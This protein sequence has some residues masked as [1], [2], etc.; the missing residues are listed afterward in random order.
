MAKANQQLP[1]AF[2]LFKPSWKAVQLNLITFIEFILV[3]ALIALIVSFLNQGHSTSANGLGDGLLI[4]DGLAGLVSLFFAPAIALTQLR[5]VKGVKIDFLPA[6]KESFAFFWKFI[7]LI[8]VM[9]LVIGIGFM[10]LI[11]PGLFMLR[12]YILAPYY[13]IDK[14]TGVFE[15]MKISAEQSK[16]FSPAIWGLIGVEF[17]CTVI[18]L[19]PLIGWLVSAALSIIYYCAPAV[20]YTQIKSRS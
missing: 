5:S 16:R 3:P 20:R 1:G 13:L 17:L 7:G 6:I 18:G 19:I 2:E 8:I 14:K 10:L 11:V 12:R 9:G 15:A 4:G